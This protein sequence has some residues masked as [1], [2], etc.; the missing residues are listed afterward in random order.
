MVELGGELID[1]GHTR[2]RS[3][4]AELGIALDDLLEGDG[5]ADSWHF[6]GAHRSEDQ[7]VEAFAPMAAALARAVAL[8]G[9]GA[10]DHRDGNPAFRA[11]DALSIAQ[12]LDR[13]G[14]SGWLRSLID[15]AYTTEMGLE[16]DAQSALNLLTFIDSDAQAFRVFGESDERFHV[17]GGNDLIT[18]A[19]GER[20]ADAI[21]PSSVLESVVADAGGY[22]VSVRRDGASRQLRAH[23][24]ILAL[25]LT[26]LREVGIDAPLAPLQR[27]A[28]E[29]S[30]LRGALSPP[31][32]GLHFAG[33][34][35]ALDTQGFM[36]GGCQSGEQ[37][38][39]AVLLQRNGTA[40]LRA[41]KRIAA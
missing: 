38:A 20:L 11:L 29:W 9:D 27:R 36:E 31:A 5:D 40:C 13:N 1:T 30:G 25:P 18:T 14:V 3:L 32:G 26:L 34:H 28:I 19:L 41:R 10:L 23:Q 8:L 35:C 17:R 22:R 2:I 33:E 16:I 4:A 12:W 21:E 6:G 7:I 24:V 37:A 39:R 15:V